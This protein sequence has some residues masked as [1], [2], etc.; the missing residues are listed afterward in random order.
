M[1]KGAA[2]KKG[3]GTK[4]WTKRVFICPRPESWTHDMNWI[5]PVSPGDNLTP[6][7]LSC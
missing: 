3:M 4:H 5:M 1:S 2:F 6:L 7:W